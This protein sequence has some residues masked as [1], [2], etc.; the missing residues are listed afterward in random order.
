MIIKILFTIILYVIGLYMIKKK[1]E[2]I[3]NGDNKYFVEAEIFF[4][5]I[6]FV[7]ITLGTVLYTFNM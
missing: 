3:E 6:Y 5:V 4:I 7:A 2:I 1:G